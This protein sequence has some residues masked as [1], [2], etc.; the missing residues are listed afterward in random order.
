LAVEMLRENKEI[1]NLI[2]LSSFVLN[3]IP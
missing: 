2:L 3:I 1:A